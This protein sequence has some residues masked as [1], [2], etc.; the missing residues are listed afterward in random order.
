VLGL[1]NRITKFAI[2]STSRLHRMWIARLRLV[3]SLFYG[4]HGDDIAAN[5]ISEASRASH[6]IET[7]CKFVARPVRH[8][9]ILSTI[10]YIIYIC[11]GQTTKPNGPRVSVQI[12][13]MVSSVRITLK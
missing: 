13:V 7:A 11:L 5:L 9:K 4:V 8:D 1:K 6:H 12:I 2:R 10:I 3:I